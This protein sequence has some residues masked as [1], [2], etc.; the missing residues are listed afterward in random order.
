MEFAERAARNKEVFRSVNE[1]IEAGAQQ[2]GV[3]SLRRQ[4]AKGQPGGAPGS[5]KLLSHS[6]R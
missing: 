2:H 1:Q 6:A 4:P 5:A 3:T